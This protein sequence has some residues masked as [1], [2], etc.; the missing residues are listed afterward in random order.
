MFIGFTERTV[1]VGE[2]RFG[3]AVQYFPVYL[4]IH[5]LRMSEIQYSIRVSVGEGT[6]IVTIDL[7][8]NWDATFGSSRLP[9]NVIINTYE[10]FPGENSTYPPQIIIRNDVRPEFNE[11]YTLRV[12]PSDIGTREHFECYDG[13]ED[14]A[15]GNYFCTVT[16]T[17]V[18]DDGEYLQ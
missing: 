4:M 11:T 16:I 3:K 2:D 12:S 6:A 7:M 9:S 18:D 10:L 17:I 8:G 14:P 13:N 5:S 15:E 1:L